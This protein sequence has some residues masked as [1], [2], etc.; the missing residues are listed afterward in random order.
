VA[1]VANLLKQSFTMSLPVVIRRER[2]HIFERVGPRKSLIL[3]LHI[4]FSASFKR[5]AILL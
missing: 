5:K 1:T 3:F 2:Y 4:R